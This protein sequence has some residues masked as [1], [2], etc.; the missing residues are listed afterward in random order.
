MHLIGDVDN[1]KA[2]NKTI[3]YMFNLKF[4]NFKQKIILPPID[5]KLPSIPERIVSIDPAGCRDIDDAFSITKV[6]NTYVLKIYIADNTFIINNKDLF[7]HMKTQTTSIYAP[8][9]T[10]HLMPEFEYC[11]LIADKPKNANICE[12][13]IQDN[14]IKSYRFYQDNIIVN[15]NLAY[16]D[17]FDD[18]LKMC[19]TVVKN[20]NFNFKTQNTKFNLVEKLMILCNHL[21]V[22][23]LEGKNFIIRTHKDTIKRKAPKEIQTQYNNYLSNAAIYTVN[24]KDNYHA[25]L[26]LN[27]YTHYTSPMRRFVDTINHLVLFNKAT[28]TVEELSHICDNCNK[29]NKQCKRAYIE[30]RKL[31]LLNEELNDYYEGYVV[32]IYENKIRFYVPEF[33]LYLS[34]KLIHRKL[35]EFYSI[36]K[37]DTYIKLLHNEE[38]MEEYHLFDKIYVTIYKRPREHYISKKLLFMIEN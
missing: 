29:V 3:L 26:G 14:N 31:Q 6:D 38:T 5:Y 8:E 28:F 27:G 33:D 11:S 25:G 18:Y 22:K 32:G 10:Y 23:E 36:E 34:H 24:T 9:K 12:I 7:N 35:S 21:V 2:M 15:E 13:I 19:N 16:D 20:L 37:T 17:P 30:W 4:K 1:Q